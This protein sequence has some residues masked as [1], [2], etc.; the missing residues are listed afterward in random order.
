MGFDVGYFKNGSNGAV[1][2]LA[3]S[4]R[5]R[6]KE[7]YKDDLHGMQRLAKGDRLECHSTFRN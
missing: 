7:A 4:T 1:H 2:M 6:R 5:T 3:Q